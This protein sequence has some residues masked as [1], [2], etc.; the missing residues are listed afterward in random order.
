L[1]ECFLIYSAESILFNFWSH[2]VSGGHN[3]EK[4]FY[5]CFNGENL[6]KS[7]QE[8]TEPEK[9]NPIYWQADLMAIKKS[10]TL[11]LFIGKILANMTQVS[12]VAPGPLVIV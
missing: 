10:I 11:H 2:G 1:H 8:T 6:R 5:I 4:H 3:R 7:L 9:K 12:D